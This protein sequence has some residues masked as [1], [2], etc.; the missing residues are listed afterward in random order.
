[1]DIEKKL[2]KLGYYLTKY[3]D[4]YTLSSLA[5]K[6]DELVLLDFFCDSKEEL[7]EKLIEDL[8][9]HLQKIKDEDENYFDDFNAEYLKTG[10]KKE[11]ENILLN[12]ESQS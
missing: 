7:Q 4:S 3:N 9:N 5:D 12:I 10:W 6:E 1:M 2:E 11:L 8:K